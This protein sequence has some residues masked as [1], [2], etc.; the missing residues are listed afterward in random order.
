MV[1]DDHVKVL[2]STAALRVYDSP[3]TLR[4][5]QRF[6]ESSIRRKA[7]RVVYDLSGR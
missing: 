7:R 6:Y 1:R 5:D 3:T 4:A 2:V